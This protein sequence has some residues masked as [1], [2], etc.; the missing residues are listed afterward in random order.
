LELQFIENIRK[1]LDGSKVQPSADQIKKSIGDDCAEIIPSPDSNILITTDTLCENI[2]FRLS[3]F[4]PLHLGRKL[5]SVNLSDIAAMGGI[6]R[7]AVLNVEIPPRLSDSSDPFW[8]FFLLGL[9]QQLMNHGAVLIGGDTVS[10]SDN[11]LSLTLT[12]IGEV[13]RGSAV[14]RSG[15]TPGDLIY[16]S[17][18]TGQAACGLELLENPALSLPIPRPVKR[19]LKKKHLL[20]E[21]R[22]ALGR[23]LSDAGVNS[24]I[25]ISDGIA[26]DLSHIA[27]ESGLKAR[28]FENLLPVSRPVRTFCR[29][30][31]RRR[32]HISRDPAVDLVLTG[33]E[34][35]ELLWTVSPEKSIPALKAACRVIGRRPFLIGRMEKGKGCFLDTGAGQLDISFRGYEH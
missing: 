19:L 31:G 1:L 26:S 24:M 14:Y 21:P 7:W 11:F 17:G 33:G 8:H 32:G 13:K 15:A 3:Y 20:P 18:F 9:N 25:D 12:I 34:D 6:P 22:V 29:S 30:L 16:C 28:V 2:H 27:E 4:S 23:A 35:F 10:A 5:A